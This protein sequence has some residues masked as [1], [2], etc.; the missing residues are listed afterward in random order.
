MVREIC[1]RR[2]IYESLIAYLSKNGGKNCTKLY[3]L[4]HTRCTILTLSPSFY[5]L[6][7]SVLWV[8]LQPAIEFCQHG[9]CTSDF[10]VECSMFCCYFRCYWREVE[11]LWE[12]QIRHVS[13]DGISS[14]TSINKVWNCHRAGLVCHNSELDVWFPW[15]AEKAKKTFYLPAELTIS[16]CL[17]SK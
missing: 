9:I 8:T 7:S 3:L 10:W 13:S 5:I 16:G 17:F 15:E 1:V 4:H 11:V 2:S 6:I 14:N 12:Q